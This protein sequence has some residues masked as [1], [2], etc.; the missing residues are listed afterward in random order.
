M[1]HIRPSMAVTKEKNVSK[2]SN[3]KTFIFCITCLE[4][5]YMYKKKA[6]HL[7]CFCDFLDPYINLQSK[8][9]S[10]FCCV[11]LEIHKSVNSL[12]KLGMLGSFSDQLFFLGTLRK[13]RKKKR[14]FFLHK[15]PLSK[16]ADL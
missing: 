16:C 4:T 5:S 15:Y 10:L 11:T 6:A 12:K 1:S 8:I 2:I 9:E 3:L 14:L 7:Q 13:T